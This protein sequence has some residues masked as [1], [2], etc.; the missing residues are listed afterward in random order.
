MSTSALRVSTSEEASP[1]DGVWRIAV[2]ATNGQFSA[3]TDFYTDP[4]YFSDFANQLASFPADRGDMATFEISSN[5]P[6]TRCYAVLQAFMYGPGQAA[7]AISLDNCADGPHA[8]RA[9]FNIPCEPA[10]L[11]RLSVQLN[12]WI[13]SPF[14][15]MIWQP[16]LERF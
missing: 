4:E 15:P 16:E 14:E 2:E 8:S 7:L 10:A 12:Q 5:N 9:H 11:N 13:S 6:V 3:A 1:Y